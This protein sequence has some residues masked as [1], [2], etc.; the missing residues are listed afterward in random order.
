MKIRSVPDK[1]YKIARR[2]PPSLVRELEM[3]ANE[4]ESVLGIV[5]L[6]LVDNDYSYIVLSQVESPV[7]SAVDLKTSIEHRDQA[8]EELHNA[9]RNYKEGGKPNFGEADLEALAASTGHTVEELMEISSAVA[10]EWWR[11]KKT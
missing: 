1:G 2:S 6:D 5:A 10:S 9:M 8:T 11:R 3:F 7:Y 4:D